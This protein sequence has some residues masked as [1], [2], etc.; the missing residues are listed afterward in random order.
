MLIKTVLSLLAMTASL[1]SC[2][3]ELCGPQTHTAAAPPRA[4]YSQADADHV[5]GIKVH[6]AT[7]VDGGVA[8]E[9]AERADW[10]AER[11]DADGMVKVS[12]NPQ[13]FDYSDADLEKWIR[14]GDPVAMYLTAYALY[15][16]DGCTAIAQAKVLLEKAFT[17]K[18]EQHYHFAGKDFPQKRVPEAA[19][20]LSHMAEACPGTPEMLSPDAYRKMAEDGGVSHFEAAFPTKE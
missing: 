7:Y 12:L 11:R 13:Y 19:L 6:T 2:H 10:L 3:D 1:S 8:P 16:R 14:A 17:V 5:F 15:N 18:S 20:A 4:L 9:A